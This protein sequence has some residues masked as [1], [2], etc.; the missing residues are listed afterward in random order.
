MLMGNTDFI[1]HPFIVARVTNTILIDSPQGMKY[2]LFMEARFYSATRAWWLWMALLL[3]AGA[4]DAQGPV[5]SA[6][7]Y[8]RLGNS[9]MAKGELDQ[10]ISNY[11]KAIEISPILADAYNNRGLAYTRKG[12]YDLA[13]ADFN[14]AIDLNPKFDRAYNN[15]GNAYVAKGD[16]ERAV[17]NYNKAISINGKLAD[18]YHN[19]GLAHYFQQQYDQAWADVHK[20]QDLGYQVDANFLEAL[21]KESGR[22]K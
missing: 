5:M 6:A 8:L 15:L 2:D 21:R 13:V 14:K 9:D 4:A 20:A 19:R 1:L 12:E 22:D 3:T 11:N 17:L 18:A 16:P 7:D 10:A